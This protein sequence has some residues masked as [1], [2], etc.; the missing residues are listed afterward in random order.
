MQLTD[1]ARGHGVV[2]PRH[3]RAE[4]RPGVLA[5]EGRH[6]ERGQV[7]NG[8]GHQLRPRRDDETD[9]VRLESPGGERQRVDG[10]TVEPVHVV[11]HDEHGRLRRRLRDEP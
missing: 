11:D 10:L 2:E 7:G 6:L 4:Q 8:S 3:H 1:D 5:A 9:G